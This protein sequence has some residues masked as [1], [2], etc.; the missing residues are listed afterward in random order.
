MVKPELSTCFVEKYFF[1]GPEHFK[2]LMTR[3]SHRYRH[4][5][6][7]CKRIGTLKTRGSAAHVH[8]RAGPLRDPIQ[9]QVE[10]RRSS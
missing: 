2:V 4:V 3:N 9:L 10:H 8:K 7:D 5:G 1:N 6:T